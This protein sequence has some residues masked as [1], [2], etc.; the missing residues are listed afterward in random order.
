MHVRFPEA[1]ASFIKAEV[2]KRILHQRDGAG[3]VTPSAACARRKNAPA[4]SR[5]PLPQAVRSA[6]TGEQCRAY[7]GA[8]EKNQEACR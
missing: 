4:A 8:F 1:D 6:S 7:P 5:M 2:Q 3:C